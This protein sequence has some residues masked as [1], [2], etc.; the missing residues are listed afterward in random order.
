MMTCECV[1]STPF[2]V[3]NERG[4]VWMIWRPNILAN[5]LTIIPDTVQH[6]SIRHKVALIVS[7]A[8]GIEMTVIG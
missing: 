5:F 3:L 8:P 4:L 7:F 2:A 1:V 6:W